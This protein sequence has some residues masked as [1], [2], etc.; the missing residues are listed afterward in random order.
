V[1]KDKR[2]RQK[3]DSADECAQGETEL[4]TSRGD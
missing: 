4:V 2:L 1:M 3:A